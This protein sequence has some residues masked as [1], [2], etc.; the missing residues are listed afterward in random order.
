MRP[1]SPDFRANRGPTDWCQLRL[2]KLH[3]TSMPSKT[4]ECTKCSNRT[5]RFRAPSL[6]GALCFLAPKTDAANFGGS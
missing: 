3:K 6:Q 4:I 2:A 5:E 1:R